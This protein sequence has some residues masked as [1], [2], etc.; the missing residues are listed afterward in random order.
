[1]SFSRY[2]HG[3]SVIKIPTTGLFLGD[4]GSVGLPSVWANKLNEL[5]RVYTTGTVSSPNYD[6]DADAEVPSEVLKLQFIC[7]LPSFHE[8]GRRYKNFGGDRI[9]ESFDLVSL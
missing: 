4:G 1:M 7:A 8:L 6:D 3:Q 2:S 5:C 9:A